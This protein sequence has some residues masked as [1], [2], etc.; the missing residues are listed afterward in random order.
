VIKEICF[1]EKDYVPYTFTEHGEIQWLTIYELYKRIPG[2]Y[3]DLVSVQPE[4]PEK[5]G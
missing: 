2:P 1:C 3:P 5:R 4:N